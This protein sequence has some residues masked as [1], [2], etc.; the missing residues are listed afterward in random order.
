MNQNLS[1]FFGIRLHF[2]N[3]HCFRPA[4]NCGHQSQITALAAH[5]FD[6]ESA[7]VRRRAL[8][9]LA[10]MGVSLDLAKNE[11]AKP[12]CELTG[13]GSRVRIFAIATN[14]EIIVARKAKDYLESRV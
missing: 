9:G 8:E 11:T 14:E 2:G 1:N 12:D 5:D 6:E 3:D 10:F 4:G 13:A 7:L